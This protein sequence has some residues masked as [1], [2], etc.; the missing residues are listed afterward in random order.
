MGLC[1]MRLEKK[2]EDHELSIEWYKIFRNDRD[3]NGGGVAIYVEDSLSVPTIKIR[4]DEL[5][6]LSLEIKPTNARSFLLVCWYSPPTF[7]V[8]ETAFE[9]LRETLGMH[10]R[11]GKEIILVGDINCDFKDKETC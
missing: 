3:S 2:I 6:I 11:E 5:E 10:D 1:D 4:S 9:N 7:S 8:D